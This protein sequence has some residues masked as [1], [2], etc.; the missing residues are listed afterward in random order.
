MMALL[1]YA[2]RHT[3]ADGSARSGLGLAIAK[4]IV[5]IHG[6]VISVESEVGEGSVFRV[7]LPKP[8]YAA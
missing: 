8:D 2:V 3:R 6:G 7:R 1:R 4:A 5:E